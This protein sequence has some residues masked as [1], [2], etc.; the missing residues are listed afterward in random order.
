MNEEQKT[1]KS[2]LERMD[3]VHI[4]YSKEELNNIYAKQDNANN[5]FTE[6]T[7]LTCEN[8]EL[9]DKVICPTTS[10]QPHL[11]GTC[12]N[13]PFDGPYG[14]QSVKE[15]MPIWINMVTGETWVD[16]SSSITECP[17]YQKSTL[18]YNEE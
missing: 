1:E 15:P 8:L 9:S 12:S 17:N 18:I 6:R 4:T 13:C 11:S 10:C 7:C 5:K 2:M 3:K 16:G 14:P